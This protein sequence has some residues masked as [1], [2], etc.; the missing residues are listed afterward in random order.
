MINDELYLY[1]FSER[2]HSKVVCAAHLLENFFLKCKIGKANERRDV[3][4]EEFKKACNMQEVPQVGNKRPAS[5]IEANEA[6]E[7]ILV[8]QNL[9]NLL[10]DEVQHTNELVVS[11]KAFIMASREEVQIHREL[12]VTRKE[13][14]GVEVERAREL[15]KVEVDKSKALAELADRE[16][17]KAKALAK[18]EIDK[19]KILAAVSNDKDE[20]ALELRRQTLEVA[21]QEME[22]AER[23]MALLERKKRIESESLAMSAPSPPTL[24]TIRQVADRE[25]VSDNI[26]VSVIR[27]IVQSVGTKFVDKAAP[28]D[29]ISERGYL[30]NQYGM[31]HYQDIKLALQKERA[32]RFAPSGQTKLNFTSAPT[33]PLPVNCQQQPSQP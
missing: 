25:G 14:A 15:A 4:L 8:R 28:I 30:V 33:T 29:K 9:N 21:K 24:C 22:L 13:M 19:A 1:I 6:P 23:D 32:N 2:G 26:P 20:N 27:S 3:M 31:E 5:D 18:V 12:V 17:E 7:D 10:C 11:K 16:V